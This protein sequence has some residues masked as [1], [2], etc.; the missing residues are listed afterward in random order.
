VACFVAVSG[1][2]GGWNTDVQMSVAAW[3]KRVQRRAGYVTPGWAQDHVFSPRQAGIAG[4]GGGCE[5]AVDSLESPR[6]RAKQRQQQ[7]KGLRRMSCELTQ[8]HSCLLAY[9]IPFY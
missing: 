8:T 1:S 9:K 3:W 4:L 6:L 5:A 7:R 2:R